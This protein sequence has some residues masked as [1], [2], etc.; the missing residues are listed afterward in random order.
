MANRGKGFGPPLD[1]ISQAVF[2]QTGKSGT[3]SGP[4]PLVSSGCSGWGQTNGCGTC[5]PVSCSTPTGWNSGCP[6]RLAKLFDGD[7]SKVVLAGPGMDQLLDRA[8]WP[9]VETI[10]GCC[11]GRE[12][13]LTSEEKPTTEDS[14]TT[15][16]NS[17]RAV[18]EAVHSGSHCRGRPAGQTRTTR[19]IL[20]I[21]RVERARFRKHDQLSYGRWQLSP[22]SH[23]Q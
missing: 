14:R 19:E 11:W 13:S 4:S 18:Y 16:L 20:I 17:H 15:C 22:N 6:N 3:R 9:P 7:R 2:L 10:G 5:L 21:I 8:Q 23:L 1:N 12:R